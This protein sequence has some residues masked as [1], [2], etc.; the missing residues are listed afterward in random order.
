MEQLESLKPFHIDS[1]IKKTFIIEEINT[2][3][4]EKGDVNSICLVNCF[5]AHFQCF[6]LV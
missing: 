4:S 6:I 2:L 1:V 3:E 5:C